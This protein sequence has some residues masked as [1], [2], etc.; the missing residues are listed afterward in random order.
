MKDDENVWNE[1]WLEIM[2]VVEHDGK[3]WEV[4]K[5]CGKVVRTDGNDHND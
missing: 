2:K 4:M 1:K 3:S 5:F